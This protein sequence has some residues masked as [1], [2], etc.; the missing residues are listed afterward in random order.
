[1]ALEI[2]N[3]ALEARIFPALAWQF[4]VSATRL[5]V[6]DAFIV[7]YAAGAQRSL[8]LHTDQSIL[9]GTIALNCL[10]EFEGGG[11]WFEDLQ[12]AI[13]VPKGHS[14]TFNGSAEHAGQAITKGVRY[15]LALFFYA[16]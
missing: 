15:I 1:V 10:G 11:T 14:I 3:N 16:V 4:G 2:L 12:M 7:K 6:F 5:R 13:R 8:P 9:S